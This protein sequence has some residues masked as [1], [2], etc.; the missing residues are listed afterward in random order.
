LTKDRTTHH[1]DGGNS[2]AGPPD[3]LAALLRR[4]LIAAGENI[5]TASTVWKLI[6]QP[7]RNTVF[8]LN[9]QVLPRVGTLRSTIKRG[10]RPSCLVLERKRGV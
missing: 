3:R 1:F 8:T 9:G 6:G 4:D 5:S 2:R 7:R 10:W